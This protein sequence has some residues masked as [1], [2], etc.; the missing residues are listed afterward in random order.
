MILGII[1]TVFLVLAVVFWTL[2]IIGASLDSSSYDG[3]NALAL[4]STIT[5]RS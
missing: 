5:A 4:I 3:T 1:A 2:V